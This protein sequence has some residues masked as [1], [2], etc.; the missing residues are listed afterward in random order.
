M[1]G[2]CSMCPHAPAHEIQAAGEDMR[3]AENLPPVL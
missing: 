2:K 1:V 3:V